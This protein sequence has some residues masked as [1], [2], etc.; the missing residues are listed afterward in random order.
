MGSSNYHSK[1]WTVLLQKSVSVL[2]TYLEFDY[3]EGMSFR[4]ANQ[5][6]SAEAAHIVP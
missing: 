1:V 6:I 5:A 4:S 2:K 3:R